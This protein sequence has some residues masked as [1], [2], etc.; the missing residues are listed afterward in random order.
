MD[1]NRISDGAV[2]EDKVGYS[3]M[4][5]YGDVIEMS[6][7]VAMENGQ[8][9][10]KGDIY[11]QACHILEHCKSFLEDHGSSL[12]RTI[13]TRMYTTDISKWEEIG[14]AHHQYFKDVKPAAT[15]V[16]VSKLI[17]RD[18]LIEIEIT[19]LKK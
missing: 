11:A 3:R 9:V 5:S 4:V 12:E 1:I 7:T 14:R 18:N 8:P 10:G 19:A 17:H 16:E 2:W 6:G 15:L 13:R